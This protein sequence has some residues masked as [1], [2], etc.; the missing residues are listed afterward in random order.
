MKK[1]SIAPVIA[2]VLSLTG[3][4]GS[5]TEQAGPKN[6]GQLAVP[7]ISSAVVYSFDLGV[8][9]P[10]NGRYYVT[11][12]T[13]KSIDV[14]DTNPVVQFVAQFKQG[15]AGCNSGSPTAPT[16][17][18]TCAGAN[19][20]MSGPDGLDI[21]GQNLYV[22]DVNALWILD[23]SSGAVV[24][25]I[26]IPSSPTFLRADEGCFDSDDNLYAIA[27][28]GADHPFMTFVDTNTQAVVA[29]VVMDDASGANSAGLEAC[30]YDHT[31]RKFFVNNDGSTAN[32]RGETDGIPA[33]AIVAA[34]PGPA[35]LTFASI[36]GTS[37]FPLGA[38]DPTGL[39]LGP[40]TDIG[41]MCRQGNVGE[42]LT[43]EILDRTSGAVVANLNIGGGDQI[44]YD[45][46]SNRWFLADSRWTA[47]GKSCG[48]G[49]ATCPLTPILAVV[50]ASQHTVVSK[51]PNGN[52]SHSVA[53]SGAR[54]LVITP[55][56]NPTAS[57]GG[58]A[59]PDGG[60]SVFS[61]M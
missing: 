6:E 4:G 43:F 26:A 60:I 23:K 59:F 42:T 29:T 30:T 56:T 55:F 58:A 18:P 31:T 24:K 38:C 35:M 5:S 39:A 12:R 28:P 15:F 48:G 19:N 16:F 52:N 32:P 33:S 53:V 49:S 46:V 44:A 7:G 8:V 10:T 11:D 34:K 13:N 37:V 47:N 3:C 41:V 22:G 61:T 2:V 17:L 36:A 14:F 45:S 54:H 9:D 40:G 51:L 20:D 50:D 57:G 21:V 1:N 25:K 27:T